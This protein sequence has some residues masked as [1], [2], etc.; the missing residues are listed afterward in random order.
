[1]PTVAPV[2][3]ESGCVGAD[4]WRRYTGHNSS[5]RC[6][7]VHFFK[8]WHGKSC[9]CL[10][11][12]IKLCKHCFFDVKM[13]HLFTPRCFQLSV[14]WM[15]KVC[16]CH[17]DHCTRLHRCS[18]PPPPPTLLSALSMRPRCHC[19][20]RVPNLSFF[21]QK[22]ELAPPEQYGSSIDEELFRVPMSNHRMKQKISEF[23]SL[24]FLLCRA[25]E[26]RFGSLCLRYRRS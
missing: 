17:C 13:V 2:Q 5:S 23:F 15:L 21:L 19:L 3:T 26:M 4:S 10:R 20:L 22:M 6:H 7:S 24:C 8:V 18:N 16:C 14:A 1:M 9:W 11:R 25:N 12:L